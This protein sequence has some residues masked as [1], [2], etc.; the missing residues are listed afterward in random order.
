MCNVHHHLG[1]IFS[2]RIPW[3]TYRILKNRDER[4]KCI[5]HTH[6]YAY[7]QATICC[8][9]RMDL[10]VCARKAMNCKRYMYLSCE[11]SILLSK[12][13]CTRSCCYNNVVRVIESMSNTFIASHR[14]TQMK[15]CFK[16]PQ[17][18]KNAECTGEHHLFSL[19]PF[20]MAEASGR[21]KN[22]FSS[23]SFCCCCSPLCND[24]K[25]T[26]ETFTLFAN[27]RNEKRARTH[28]MS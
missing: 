15:C 13:L 5:T 24:M 12:K 7:R 27:K 10:C 17:I 4:N 8:A 9:I 20:K 18:D 3:K 19:S 28:I 23:V 26:W 6:T 22:W 1:A 25:Q 2:E 14:C 21:T 11:C 16:S